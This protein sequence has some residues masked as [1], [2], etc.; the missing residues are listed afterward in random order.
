MLNLTLSAFLTYDTHYF[1][2]MIFI[3]LAHL[4]KRTKFFVVH[5]ISTLVIYFFESLL[6]KSSYTIS[7][8]YHN[9]YQIYNISLFLIRHNLADSGTLYMMIDLFKITKYFAHYI[10]SHI[11]CI[12]KIILK[13]P[14]A[15][16]LKCK[17]KNPT[18]S[19]KFWQIHKYNVNIIIIFWSL[20]FV[21]E[22][23]ETYYSDLNLAH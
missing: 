14:C 9:L 3:L 12:S 13:A 15:Q 4:K 8:I 7:W 21:Q 20:Y 19:V 10:C 16:I 6:H 11:I 17:I 1:H 22:W 23:S 18:N 2:W 5:V